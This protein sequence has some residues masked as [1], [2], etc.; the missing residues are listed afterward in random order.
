MTLGVAAVA[1]A[2][3]GRGAGGRAEPF[4]LR[5]DR[6]LR[7]FGGGESSLK[8]AEP[9]Q[10]GGRDQRRAGDDRGRPAPPARQHRAGQARRGQY[11]RG[12]HQ[13]PG[14]PGLVGLRDRPE[15]PQQQALGGE[16]HGRA[17]DSEP[18]RLAR[19]LGAD[20]QHGEAAR[21]AGR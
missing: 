11:L 3:G 13:L 8:D 1:S 9:G 5:T 21:G 15:P 19:V 10:R 17:E 12:F 20:G 18:D 16:F 6:V 7:V 4:A 14:P 2:G